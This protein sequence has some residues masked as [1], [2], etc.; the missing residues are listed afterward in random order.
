MELGMVRTCTLL[1][2]VR[3][4]GCRADDGCGP[5]RV[6]LSPCHSGCSWRAVSPYDK[7]ERKHGA[8]G[9]GADLGCRR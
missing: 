6:S 3:A 8:K 7:L 9:W 4:G 2:G 1:A 5:A